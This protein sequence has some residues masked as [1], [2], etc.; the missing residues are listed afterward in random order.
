ME[1]LGPSVPCAPCTPCN[2][3]PDEA[4]IQ[5][6]NSLPKA[7]TICPVSQP[8]IGGDLV[9][10]ETGYKIIKR[11]RQY[12][13]P[14]TPWILAPNTSFHKPA[15]QHIFVEWACSVNCRSLIWQTICQMIS[16]MLP[17]LS[18]TGTQGSFCTPV[19]RWGHWSLERKEASIFP[20][21]CDNLWVL[22]SRK[23]RVCE[24]QVLLREARPSVKANLTT[25]YPYPAQISFPH[26]PNFY[27]TAGF[28]FL[29]WKYVQE[30]Y[31]MLWQYCSIT[32]PPKM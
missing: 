25:S 24:K 16:C 19:F 7:M 1:L 29:K 30:V 13:V 3:R 6:W 26:Y 5:E 22:I 2:A 20:G 31:E 11:Y 17:H 21:G 15:A 8:Q 9:C 14:R 18:L 27:F 32:N 4:T 23:E 10:T 12:L 28:Q